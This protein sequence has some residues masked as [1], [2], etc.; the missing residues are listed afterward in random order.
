LLAHGFAELCR[1]QAREDVGGAGR[2]YGTM[3]RTGFCGYVCACAGIST[4][5]ATANSTARDRIEV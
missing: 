3:M 5:A 2:V 4:V 1:Q